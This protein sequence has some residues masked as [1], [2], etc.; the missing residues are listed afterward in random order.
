MRL[1]R[2]LAASL[3][4]TPQGELEPSA[5]N[6]QAVGRISHGLVARSLSS[7]AMAIDAPTAGRR[8]RLKLPAP[9]ADPHL[10]GGFPTPRARCQGGFEIQGSAYLTIS[11]AAFDPLQTYGSAGIIQN[12]WREIPPGP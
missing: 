4:G 6:W 11:G 3:I 12:T 1:A 10:G 9:R 7:A 2:G 8:Q 5:C